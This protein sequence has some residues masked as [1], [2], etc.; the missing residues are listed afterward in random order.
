MEGRRR[1]VRVEGSRVW[2]VE[3]GGGL[4]SFKSQGAFFLRLA[5]SM[6]MPPPPPP[7][8]P[9]L[10]RKGTLRHASPPP[11]PLPAFTVCQ[12]SIGAGVEGGRL[13][14]DLRCLPLNELL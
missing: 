7:P 13:G 12:A 8:H 2:T 6:R 3:G 5:V 4:R 14:L 10:M 9:H 1:G 11:P